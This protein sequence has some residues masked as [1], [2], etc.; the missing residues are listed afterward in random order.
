MEDCERGM[1]EIIGQEY[2]SMDDAY[3]GNLSDAVF[4]K[5][6]PNVKKLLGYMKVKVLPKPKK[7]KK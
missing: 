3:C 5:E 2:D 1:V 7:I 4:D 6:L